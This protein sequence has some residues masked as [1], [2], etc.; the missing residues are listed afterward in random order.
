[1]RID[2]HT[3]SACSDGTDAPAVLVAAAAAA[4]LDVMAL[5]DHDT[6]DGIDEALAAGAGHGVRVVVGVEMSTDL[7][8]ESVHLLGYGHDPHDPR[9]AAE[10]ARVRAGRAER[11]PET[12]RLLAAAGAPVSVEDVMAQ[13]VDTPSVGRPHVADALVAAGHVA[14]RREAFDRYLAE[15]QPAFVPRYATPL[16]EAI[17]L[18]HGAGGAAVLAHPWGR[19]RR[20]ALPPEVIAGLVA[21]HGLDGIEVWHLDHDE[22]TR[23]ELLE[24][25]TSLG[26]IPTGSSDHHGAGKVGHPLGAELTPPASLAALEAVFAR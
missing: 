9:L 17:D 5:T 15:G 12:C 21:D 26:L 25:A 4:G 24:L 14:D 1:M 10:L 3:H 23:A 6:H 11:L 19:G 20:D 7:G 13:A 16:G 2:L 22:T 8:G 18:I